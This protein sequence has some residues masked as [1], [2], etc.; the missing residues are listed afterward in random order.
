MTHA[1]KLLATWMLAAGVIPAAVAADWPE[2]P[3]PDD[4]EGEW[5]SR[6]MIHNGI[7]MRAA[8]FHSKE[9]P[10]Q[11][12]RFYEQKWPGQ[13]VVT[14]LGNKKIVAHATSKHSI[15]I[16]LSGGSNGSQGQIG[17]IELIKQAPKAAPG[18]DFIKPAGTQVIT[19][20]VYMDNPGR[21]LSMTAPMSPFQADAYYKARLPANGWRSEDT[22]TCAMMAVSCVSSYAN[23][24]QQMTITF[25]RKGD[26]TDVV[27]NQISR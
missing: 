20:T 26:T 21:T 15:T 23:G 12:I 14:D 11:L 3:L 4:T 6:H 24:K 18:A 17:I 2:L 1:H 8:R 27:V 9:T 22:R 7:P 19:D 13:V 10:D 16:E 5:V 25:N